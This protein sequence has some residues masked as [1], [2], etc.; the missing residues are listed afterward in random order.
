M[1]KIINLTPHAITITTGEHAGTYPSEGVARV[2]GLPLGPVVGLPPS[3]AD[4]VYVVSIIV[5]EA[6]PTRG[7][8]RVPGEQVRD[9]AGRIVGCESL[10]LPA[11]CSPA[12]AALTRLRDGWRASQALAGLLALP[13]DS[14]TGEQPVGTRRRGG[15]PTMSVSWV[16]RAADGSYSVVGWGWGEQ[17]WICDPLAASA[18]LDWV[19]AAP[20]PL[21]PLAPLAPPA[22]PSLEGAS[23][24]GAA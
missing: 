10:A 15:Q 16:C 1:T 19:Y 18:R 12:L 9:G 24:E 14:G 6:L 21:A 7:D 13:E 23:F 20:A 22:G 17:Q 11:D 2:D 3:T 5:A 4:T 8:L